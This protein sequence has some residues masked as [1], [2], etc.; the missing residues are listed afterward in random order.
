MEMDLFVNLIVAPDVE[1]DDLLFRDYDGHGDPIA[2]GNADCLDSGLFACEMVIV[3][4]GLKGVFFQIAQ[5]ESDFL[6]QFRM[7][8][9]ERPGNAGEMGRP[10][11]CIHASIFQP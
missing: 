9:Y 4:M 6:L 3:E 8:L 2:I 7:A 5:D 10:Y 11:E 1:Q